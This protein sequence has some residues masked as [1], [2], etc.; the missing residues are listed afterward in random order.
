MAHV[1]AFHTFVCAVLTFW[2]GHVHTL[3]VSHK[4]VNHI[5][6]QVWFHVGEIFH[7]VVFIGAASFSNAAM[8]DMEF[9]DCFALRPIGR[10]RRDPVLQ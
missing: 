10:M 5:G 7:L 2:L 3:T 8:S 1:H 6:K 4:L 9:G